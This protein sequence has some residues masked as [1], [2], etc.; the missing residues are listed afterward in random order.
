MM[1]SSVKPRD[2]VG[3]GDV[4][5]LALFAILTAGILPVAFFGM[6]RIRRRRLRRFF[7]EGLPA[8]GEVLNITVTHDQ[9]RVSYEFEA[10]GATHRDS[11]QLLPAVAERWRPGDRVQILYLPQRNYDSV[12]VSPR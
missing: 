8:V 6:A 3:V 2:E 5:K 11:D 7:R 4:L 1:D 10:D 12:I 9:A